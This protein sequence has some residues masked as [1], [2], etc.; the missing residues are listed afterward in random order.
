MTAAFTRYAQTQSFVCGRDGRKI[1]SAVAS[2]NPRLRDASGSPIGHIGQ[3][4]AESPDALAPVLSACESHLRGQ[5]VHSVW[6]PSTGGAHRPHRLMTAGFE[7]AAHLGEPRNPRWLP[8]ALAQHGYSVQHAWS[9]YDLEPDQVQAFHAR[10]ASAASDPA[11]T[12]RYGVEFPDFGDTVSLAARLHPLLDC[13]WASHFG[14]APM[15]RDELVQQMP[16]MLTFMQPGDLAI[17]RD[18]RSGADAGIA[19][20]MRDAAI[21]RILLHTIA[22]SAAV[23][24]TGAAYLLMEAGLGIGVRTGLPAIAVLVDQSFRAFDR[25]SS[26]TRSYAVYGKKL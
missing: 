12:G 21:G 26:P 23:R 13:V 7:T 2:V 15:D 11:L 8:T 5:S 14:Y 4:E 1:G 18:R 6:A 17:L 9:G 3:L 20:V 25:I 10:C 22:V 19:Y 16:G 24:K